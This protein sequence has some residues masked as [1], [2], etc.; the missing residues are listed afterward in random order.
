MLERPN[1]LVIMTDQQSAYMMSCTGNDTLR[2]PAL[3]RLAGSGIRFERAYA[4]NPVCVPS[5][6]SLQTGRM[7]SAIGMRWNEDFF[8]PDD[9]RAQSLGP[10]FSAAGYEAVYAGKVH[11]PGALKDV[12][13][14]GY[15]VLS[16][17]A[18]ESCADACAEFLGQFGIG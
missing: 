1:I 7:P 8:V 18:R 12:E 4:T 3:D 17:D 16:T 10:I 15:R 9:I 5:R 13:Q 6:F 14:H 11:L 2:T